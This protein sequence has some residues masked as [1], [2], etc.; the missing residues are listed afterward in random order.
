MGQIKKIGDEY[1]I[2]F[3]ARG[4]LYQQKA[5]VDKAQAERLLNEIE[6]KIACGE[7]ATIVRDVDV[8]IFFQTF[9]KYAAKEHT[10]KT[11]KH[12]QSLIDNFI[13]F[14]AQKIHKLSAITPRVI[15]EY[16]F[17]LLEQKP[18]ITAEMINFYLFL[19]R[20]I[21]DYSINLGFLNDNPA[22]HVKFLKQA[23]SEILTEK[24]RTAK[25]FIEKGVSF[26]RLYQLLEID[27]ISETI[28]Y[29]PF[30]L[31]KRGV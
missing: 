22:F 30:W 29:I 19:L 23:D 28:C 27:D 24:E 6:N 15:E 4:L 8:D 21:F 18:R 11:L 26:S 12:Y 20:D 13:Q 9:L 2:E 17:Y 5:G 25:S 1:Y 7:T 10:P 16:R 31:E 14:L 3:Y